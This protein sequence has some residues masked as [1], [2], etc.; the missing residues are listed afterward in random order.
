L[1]IDRLPF[2]V[3]TEPIIEARIEKIRE[4]GDDPFRHYQLPAAV[5]LLRQGAGRLIRRKTDRGVIA[6]LDPRLR[7]KGYGKIFLRSLPP[8][9]VVSDVADVEKFFK[10]S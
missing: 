3:P 2:D 9:T 8:M 7:T 6:L 4:N 5:L 1:V 10:K